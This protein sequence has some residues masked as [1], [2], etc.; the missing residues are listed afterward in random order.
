LKPEEQPLT[1]DYSDVLVCFAK[2][3]RIITEAVK[4]VKH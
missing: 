2:S 4:V 3:V 1:G